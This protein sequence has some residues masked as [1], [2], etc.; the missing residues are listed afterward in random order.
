MFTWIV[1]KR[2]SC[3]FNSPR[4]ATSLVFTLEESSSFIGYYYLDRVIYSIHAGKLSASMVLRDRVRFFKRNEFLSKH[5]VE[6]TSRVVESN[7]D[8]LND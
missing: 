4:V 1:V 3:Y 6:G 5:G 8:Y 2:S 7:D